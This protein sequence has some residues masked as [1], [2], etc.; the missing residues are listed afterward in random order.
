[1]NWRKIQD[2]LYFK[3]FSLAAVKKISQ[4]EAWQKAI[5]ELGL[6]LNV[7]E[8]KKLHCG[9]MRTNPKM[10]RLIKTLGKNY[11]IAC[12]SKNTRSQFADVKK[13]FPELEKL[14]GKNLINVWEYSLPKASPKT[15]NFLCKRFKVKPPEI[16]YIDDQQANLAAPKQLGV[17]TVLYKTFGQ[18]KKEINEAIAK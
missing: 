5:T 14:F 11:K 15:V 18:A 7:P 4:Q 3:Y 12:L 13:M 17:K 6:P 9:L 1:M 16:L 2:I 10:L 8:L